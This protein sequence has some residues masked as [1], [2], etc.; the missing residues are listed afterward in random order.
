MPRHISADH[1][2]VDGRWSSTLPSLAEA[3]DPQ[4]TSGAPELRAVPHVRRRHLRLRHR[5]T[6]RARRAQADRLG[7]G[8]VARLESDGEALDTD[9]LAARVRGALAE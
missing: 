9:S 2:A 7:A 1:A 5:R 8:E 4:S 3:R 6:A